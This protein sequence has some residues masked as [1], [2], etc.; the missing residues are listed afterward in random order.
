VLTST[1]HRQGSLIDSKETNHA[2]VGTN[3]TGKVGTVMASLKKLHLDPKGGLCKN[4][5]N[6]F[7]QITLGGIQLALT[8]AAC[9]AGAVATGGASCA[10]ATGGQIAV[11]A[12]IGVTGTVA[13]QIAKGVLLP[14]AATAL[15]GAACTGVEQAYLR[16]ACLYSGV[17]AM[18]VINQS[19]A[20]IGRPLKKRKLAEYQSDIVNDKIKNIASKSFSQRYLSFSNPLSLASFVAVSQPLSLPSIVGMITGTTHAFPNLV[21]AGGLGSI[22]KS[23]FQKADAE[24]NGDQ[25]ALD[26]FDQP[27][28]G[29]DKET[30][31]DEKYNTESNVQ[32]LLRNNLIKDDG[33]PNLDGENIDG[34]TLPETV[35]V[36]SNGQ[37]DIEV[38]TNEPTATLASSTNVKNYIAQN[39]TPTPA[40]QQVTVK[41]AVVDRAKKLEHYTKQCMGRDFKGEV[42]NNN[43]LYDVDGN[44]TSYCSVDD[45]SQESEDNKRYNLFLFDMQ[46]GEGMNDSISNETGNDSAFVD[47]ASTPDYSGDGSVDGIDLADI[48]GSTTFTQVPGA[49]ATLDLAPSVIENVTKMVEAARSAGI[50]LCGWGGRS[51]AKQIELR[52]QHCGTSQYDIY[53]KPS[54]QC[55]PPTARPGTGQH[56]IGLAIDFYANNASITRTSKDYLWL[57][58]NASKYGFKNLPSE[59]WHWSTTG[60]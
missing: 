40:V 49:C 5:G 50:E 52:K 3:L 38:A 55:K 19:H 56:E 39:S 4:A 58:Q 47:S 45:G 43:P 46:T 42:S 20:G 28:I 35:S 18:N 7:Y 12:L 16:V 33:T 60:R 37:G 1:S 23:L 53:Q 11:A 30:L 24:E 22:S 27:F 25:V 34:G 41:S 31:A 14:I 44:E 51:A 32:Y 29:W 57:T 9:T 15:A 17:K 13:L 26:P 48:E 8:V 54:S 2:R 10:A 36:Y 6:V 21:T 59:P